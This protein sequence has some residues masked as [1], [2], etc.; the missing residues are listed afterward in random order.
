MISLLT[1]VDILYSSNIYLL[2][3]VYN[4]FDLI[5]VLFYLDV[6]CNFAIKEDW[7]IQEMT[8]EKEQHKA[9]RKIVVLNGLKTKNVLLSLQ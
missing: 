3:F 1:I 4:Y 5:V 6:R 8:L 9:L 2:H 7:I